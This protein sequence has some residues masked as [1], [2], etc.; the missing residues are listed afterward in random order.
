MEKRG[1]IVREVLSVKAGAETIRSADREY[2]EQ[3]LR[4]WAELMKSHVGG[5]E[6]KGSQTVSSVS[7]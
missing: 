7:E 3:V 1:R 4:R 2:Q 6:V 5:G